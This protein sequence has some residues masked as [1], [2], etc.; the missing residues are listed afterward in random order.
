ML[1]VVLLIGVVLAVGAAVS[2]AWLMPQ[3][4]SRRRVRHRLEQIRRLRPSE[5]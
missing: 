1:D 3:M 4:Q 2:A 5:R